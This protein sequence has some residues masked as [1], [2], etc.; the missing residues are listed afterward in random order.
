LFDF[1]QVFGDDYLHFSAVQLTDER[2]DREAD[3]IARLL[4]LAPGTRV[5]DIPCGHGRVA[6]LRNA[7][8]AALEGFDERGEPL[9][10]DSGRMI[11]V[12]TA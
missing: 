4:E 1:E 11:V 7:G 2:A 9:G 5:L 8:L 10:L 3:L 12:A 6:S